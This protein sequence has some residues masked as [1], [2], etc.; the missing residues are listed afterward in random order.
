MKN[1]FHGFTKSSSKDIQLHTQDAGNCYEQWIIYQH[2]HN[3]SVFLLGQHATFSLSLNQIFSE[4]YLSS[5]GEK[6][7]TKVWFEM[8]ILISSTKPRYIY[9]PE[10]TGF[11]PK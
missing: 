7:G 8:P 11:D 3:I 2:V 10:T 5:K 9:T 4:T 1:K 6:K